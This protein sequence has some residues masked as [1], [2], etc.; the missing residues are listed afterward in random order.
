MLRDHA[1][2]FIDLLAQGTSMGGTGY[3]DIAAL[4]FLFEAPDEPLA[5]IMT[6]IAPWG[7]L[8]VLRKI[9]VE[10]L[11][12]QTLRPQQ[13][14]SYGRRT[15]PDLDLFKRSHEFSDTLCIGYV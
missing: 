7:G 14:K 5:I 12:G 13:F 11:A 8:P 4:F 15:F 3:L 2:P 9:P 6:E 10:G 1:D